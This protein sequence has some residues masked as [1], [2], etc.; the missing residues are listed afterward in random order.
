MNISLFV[1]LVK[2]SPHLSLYLE[3]VEWTAYPATNANVRR[4]VSSTSERR[5]ELSNRD[6][7]YSNGVKAGLR[8]GLMGLQPQAHRKNRPTTLVPYAV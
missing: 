3:Y 2:H 1:K 5:L 7:E 6:K 4:V 8:R